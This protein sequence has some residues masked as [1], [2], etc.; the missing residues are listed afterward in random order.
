MVEHTRKQPMLTGKWTELS[1]GLPGEDVET[2]VAAV[3]VAVVVEAVASILLLF[4]S[5]NVVS[6]LLAFERF[7]CLPDA[8]VALAGGRKILR[9]FRIILSW[10]RSIPA[11]RSIEDYLDGLLDRQWR[12]NMRE[13]NSR[14]KKTRRKARERD[15]RKKRIVLRLYTRAYG[16]MV[17]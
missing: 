6:V 12:P 8:A 5:S 2:T 16:W 1:F 4:E 11:I 13:S 7:P 17:K 9:N 3:V 14:R 10:L 15:A